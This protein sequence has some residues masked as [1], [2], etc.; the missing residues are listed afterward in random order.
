MTMTMR[1][2]TI[3]SFWFVAVFALMGLLIQGCG[4]S[5]GGGPVPDADPVGYYD[6]TGTASV[7]DGAGGTTSVNDLQAIVNGTRFV[8]MSVATGLGYDGTV[9]SIKG[10]NYTATVSVYQNGTLF[11]T[12]TVS[13]SITEGSTISGTLTGVGSATGPSNGSFTLNYALS[14]NETAALSRVENT[15]IGGDD[16]WNG[17]VGGAV[18]ET[19]FVADAA[20][21][22]TN[23]FNTPQ[24]VFAG[25]SFST[26]TIVPVANTNLYTVTVTLTTCTTPAVDGVYTGLATTRALVDP[27]DRLVMVIS[28]ADYSAYA[29]YFRS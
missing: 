22:I 7:D 20:G 29:E 13:G 25:C 21:N 8:A 6:V 3:R 26:G 27:D 4:S 16:S 9:T 18:I 11:D 19:A 2:H 12:A 17:Y 24:G 1:T 5:G 14:N 10:K 23:D 28:N 15:F